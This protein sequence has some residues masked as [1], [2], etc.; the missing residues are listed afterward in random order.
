[1]IQKKILVVDDEKHLVRIISF[2]L[3]RN[4]YIVEQAFNGEEALEALCHFKPD[5]IILD[6]MMPKKT[7]LEVCEIIKNDPELKIIPV[8][9]LTAKGQESDRDQG[10]RYGADEYMI[11]PFSPRLLLETV[12][13][14]LNT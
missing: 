12:E 1:M 2:N 14:Y 9:M 8:I 6:V 10:S 4:G 5:L 7:G 13:K 11:K 3:K